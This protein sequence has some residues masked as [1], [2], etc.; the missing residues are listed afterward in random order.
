MILEEMSYILY[1]RKNLL[2]FILKLDVEAIALSTCFSNY[3]EHIHEV[4]QG[5]EES[6]R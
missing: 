5:K 6:E 3:Q 2:S 4:A 1:K